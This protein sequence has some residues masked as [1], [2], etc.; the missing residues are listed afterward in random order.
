M[1]WKAPEKKK[2]KEWAKREP[3]GL[4]K[5]SHKQILVEKEPK[6]TGNE[7]NRTKKQ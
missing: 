7:N 1:I 2:T 6:Q 4:T 3:V 5:H